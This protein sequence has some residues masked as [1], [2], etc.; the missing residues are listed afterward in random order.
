MGEGEK[1]C[2]VTGGRGFAARHLVAM[3]IKYDMFSVRIAD[4]APNINLDSDEENGVLGQALK[5]GRA[6]YFCADLRDKS[7]VLKGSYF[8]Q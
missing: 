3:L 4:L 2:M 5:S 6:H 7:Q 1:W 8:I